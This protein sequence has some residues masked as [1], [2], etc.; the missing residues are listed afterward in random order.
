MST[1][2]DRRP[3]P[4]RRPAPVRPAPVRRPVNGNEPASS[5]ELAQPGEQVLTGRPVPPG[6]RQRHHAI[7]HEPIALVDL[8]DRVLSG[9]VVITG[10]VRLT[11]ADV[12]LVTVSLRALVSSV[13]TVLDPPSGEEDQA[14][15]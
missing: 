9:G 4:A 11:I 10:E 5:G 14:G 6:E 7:A 8:L 13:S 1:H 12:D 2:G 3:A 15:G